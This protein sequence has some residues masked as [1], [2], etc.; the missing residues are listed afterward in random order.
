MPVEPKQKDDIAGDGEVLS[1]A[2]QKIR[3]LSETRA[4]I[5]TSKRASKQDEYAVHLIPIEGENE[6]EAWD[7]AKWLEKNQAAERAL[8]QEREQEDEKLYQYFLKCRNPTHTVGAQPAPPH[9]IYFVKRPGGM[10][11]DQDWFSTY[12]KR[13]AVWR[14]D[15]LCQVCLKMGIEGARLHYEW[16]DGNRGLFVPDKRWVWKVP[17][18]PQRAKIEGMTRAFDLPYESSNAWRAEVDKK[19]AKAIQEGVLTNG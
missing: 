6:T 14:Q 17:R 11:G 19:V 7:A 2:A 12:K 18:S 10:V 4:A 13:N 9:G 5:Q 16:Q 3:T 15:I 1:D 8:V